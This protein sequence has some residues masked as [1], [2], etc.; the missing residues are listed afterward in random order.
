[1]IPLQQRTQD[2]FSLERACLICNLIKPTLG[3]GGDKRGAVSPHGTLS[4]RLKTAMRKDNC[5]ADR[6]IHGVSGSHLLDR[7]LL[8]KKMPF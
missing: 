2:N 6:D 8:T 3:Q 4:L 7:R 1:M 5:K